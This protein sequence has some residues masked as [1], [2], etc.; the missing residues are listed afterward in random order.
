MKEVY[1]YNEIGTLLDQGM[2]T[3][4]TCSAL[5]RVSVKKPSDQS[6]TIKVSINLLIG[7]YSI[8]VF[9]CTYKNLLDMLVAFDINEQKEIWEVPT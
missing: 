9:K 2:N 6:D 7:D 5:L 4:F 1:S 8:G 3:V